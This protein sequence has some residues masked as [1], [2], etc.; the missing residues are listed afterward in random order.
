MTAAKHMSVAAV[1]QI[2]SK[3]IHSHG[4]DDG[5]R[6]EGL[7]ASAVAAPQAT[8]G[9]ECIMSD[10]IEIAAVYLFYLCNN[11]PFIDGNK[12]TALATCLVFLVANGVLSE[13]RASA[14]D[15]NTWE[16]FVLDIA[17]SNIDR[18]ETTE[19]LRNL[20]R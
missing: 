1:K 4:G 20:L 10:H 17:C 18:E 3:A 9:G 2:H 5:L 19:K 11:H 12:R 13:H 16:T 8:S 6:D 7:L 15:V 14:L